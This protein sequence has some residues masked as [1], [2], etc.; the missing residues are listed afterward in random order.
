MRSCNSA[1][2]PT[3]AKQCEKCLRGME[4]CPINVGFSKANYCGLKRVKIV[5]KGKLKVGVIVESVAVLK[6]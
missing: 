2:G 5:K 6:D 3:A 1:V 4:I